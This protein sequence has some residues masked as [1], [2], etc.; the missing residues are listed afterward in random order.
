MPEI[1]GFPPIAD[2]RARVL[3][4]GSMP[5]EASLSKQQYYAH[6]RNAFWPIMGALFAAYPELDY[7]QRKCILLQNGV[8]VWDV[9]ARCRR[10]GSADSDIVRNSIQTND[11]SQFFQRHAAIERV[12]FNGATA[13]ALYKKYVFPV[14][15]G[16]FAALRYQ[17]LPS[18]SPAFAGM[19]RQQKKEAWR[20]ILPDV[21]YPG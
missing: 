19:T 18:T 9:V 7:V 15:N 5:S 13:E 1:Q 3:V 10:Q 17:R 21:G 20:I 12:F 14:L 8:A 16:K 4:L 11:F 6:P 2:S